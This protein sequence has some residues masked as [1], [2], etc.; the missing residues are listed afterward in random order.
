M[1]NIMTVDLED[2]FS[3]EVLADVLPRESWHELDS[4]VVRNTR[5]ILGLFARKNVK[6][7]FFV[8]GWIAD[9]YPGLVAEVA[10]AGHEIA[11]HSYYHRKVSSLTPEQFRKDTDKAI[12]AIAKACASIPQG[13]RSPSWGIRRDMTWAFDI[14]GELLGTYRLDR[15]PAPVSF[16]GGAVGYFGYDLCHFI[17]RLPSTAI[18]DLEFPESYF[19][20]YDTVLAFDHLE[21]KVYLIATGFPELE[22]SCR[23]KQARLRLEE[24][25]RW[26]RS[27]E[28][29]ESRSTARGEGELQTGREGREIWLGSN[30]TPEEYIKA[31]K[32]PVRPSK[33]CT[34]FCWKV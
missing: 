22:E 6:A 34:E 24:M 1:K 7:T 32:G 5:L 14:L 17:E 29:A 4:V 3:V 25:K 15:C 20:F 12:N 27:E 26:L 11:C 2:W 31:V 21:G 23:A 28:Q 10:N 30:F 18:D 33:Y 13:Y 19:A 9:R 16:L 8:L